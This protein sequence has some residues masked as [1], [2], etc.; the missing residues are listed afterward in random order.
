MTVNRGAPILRWGPVLFVLC[1]L[2]PEWNVYAAP[3][4]Q[5]DT[6]KHL[7]VASCASSTCH[8]AVSE[9]KESNVWRNEYRIWSK[10]DTHA[11]A[12]K[13]L[14]NAQS[15][16]IAAK[17]GIGDSTKAKECLDCHA[18]N[19]SAAARGP[20]FQISDGVGCEACHGGSEK[21]IKTHTEPGVSH[22]QNL[23]QGMYPTED[24][25]A[26]AELCLS[27]HLGN[28]NQFATHRIMGAGHPR[29]SFELDTFT[30]LQPAHYSVDADYVKRKGNITDPT[31]WATG[32][33]RSAKR[34]ASLLDSHWFKAPSMVP[35]PSF[36]DCHACHHP[37]SDLRW[38]AS[39]LGAGMPPG[40]IRLND[41]PM[42]MLKVIADRIN[43]ALGQELLAATRGLHKAS[44]NSR[45]AVIGAAKTLRSVCDRL[46]TSIAS[47]AFA[48]ADLRAMM[49][50]I[51]V[52]SGNGEYRDYTSAEQAVMAIDMMVIT[53]GAA[54][55]VKGEMDKLYGLVEDE[56]HFSPKEFAA[57]L[58]TMSPRFKA[59]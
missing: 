5:Q 47:A 20:K 2:L 35:E 24:P 39:D 17:L 28:E 45:E 13:V 51:V 52:Q 26:R 7:G 38:Q 33:V 27:C 12:F 4:P 15:K 46:E 50:A 34:I 49:T 57:A 58:R 32:Q 36:F 19:V 21:W 53:L 1:V 22:A 48:P 6:N 16:A 41:A 40:A 18:D 54:D 14:Q 8:G 9:S 31:L 30:V 42:S 10:H 44:L 55:K 29:M 3:F 59:L 23:A 56:H 43:P 25:A 37:M 11:Q